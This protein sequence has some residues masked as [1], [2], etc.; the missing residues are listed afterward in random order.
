MKTTGDK[1]VST[2]LASALVVQVSG[3]KDSSTIQLPLPLI[4]IVIIMT[5][6]SHIRRIMG[7]VGG[8]R[9]KNDTA[10]TVWQKVVVGPKVVYDSLVFGFLIRV[11]VVEFHRGEESP[12]QGILWDSILSHPASS[13]S[14]TSSTASLAGLSLDILADSTRQGCRSKIKCIYIVMYK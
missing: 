11:T 13:L 4:I 10:T 14:K 5:L 7:G 9:E 3:R 8:G 6:L 12:C 2:L 1:H